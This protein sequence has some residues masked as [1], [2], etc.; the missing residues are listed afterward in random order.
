MRHL[1][2]LFF[3]TLIFS[4]N[5]NIY[6]EESAKDIIKKRKSLFSANYKTAKRVDILSKDLEFEK[7]SKYMKEVSENYLE[8]LNLFP[9]NTKEGHGTEALPSIWENKDEFNALMQK[10]SDDMIKLASVI[11]ESDDIRATLK[12][13]M[14]KNCNACH[15]KFRKPH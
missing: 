6:S 2:I 4:V 5:T 11:E 12:Q 15:S 7:A 10:S 9:E 8:L 13:Y 1:K 3:V 14:W